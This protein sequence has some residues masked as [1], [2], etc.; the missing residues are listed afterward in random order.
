MARATAAADHRQAL[1]DPGSP[2]P[3]AGHGGLDV[4][5]AALVRDLAEGPAGRLLRD[6]VRPQLRWLT[7][8][9][10]AWPLAAATAGQAW[11]MEPMLNHVFLAHDRLMLLLVPI[12]V[13]ALALLKGVSGYGQ[14]V[15][16]ARIGQR[17]IAALQQRLLDRLIHADLGYLVARRP[18]HVVWRL[19]YDTQQLR[20]RDHHGPDHRGARFFGHG[21]PGRADGRAGLAEFAGLALLGC[22]LAIWPIQRLGRRMRE[23]SRQTQTHMAKLTAQ[24]DQTFLGVRQVKADNRERGGADD[25]RRP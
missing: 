20:G 10:C 8:P 16:M 24:L 25:H 3:G 19:T 12:A 9:G 17:V 11:I 15:L 23:G 1:P 13:I 14:A 5:P 4:Q 21:E 18:G 22:P 2:A 6:H 7:S